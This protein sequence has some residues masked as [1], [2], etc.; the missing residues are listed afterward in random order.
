MSPEALRARL[1]AEVQAAG[2]LPP[3]W[4]ETFEAVPRHLF[5]PDT[6]WVEA[7]RGWAPLSRQSRPQ[8][9]WDLVYRDGYVVTQ[10]DD[11]RAA[12]P[13]AVGSYSTSS[14]SQPSLVMQMLRQLDPGPGDRVLEIGTGSGYNAALL[15][16]RVGAANVTTVEISESLAQQARI[17]LDEAGFGQTRVLVGDGTFGW[18]PAAPYDRVIS[19]AGVQRVPYDWVAQTRA[20]G[21]IVTPWGTGYHNDAL[22]KLTVGAD[23]TASGGFAGSA[24]F[25][26]MRDQRVILGA[27]S[28]YVNEADRP[29]QRQTRLDPQEMFGRGDVD[30]AISTRVR[31]CSWHRF[32]ATGGPG[33]FTV[34]LVHLGPGERSWASI[35]REPDGRHVVEQY[36]PR[37]LWDEVEAAYAWWVDIGR[38]ARERFGL[39]V[40][41]DRQTVWL[42]T[43]AAPVST[44]SWDTGSP[45]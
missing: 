45:A 21:V 6:V 43:S 38:P 3:R 20:G 41:P 1:T 15:A 19:T 37:R 28:D 29:D 16:G 39:T 9:W 12:E 5:I 7:D 2:A 42:D 33:E 27:L 26:W 36:G 25:M 18:R 30:F 35:D 44:Q 40:T 17:T 24:P 32:D 14:A 31:D 4:R 34:W 22:V 13:G 11:G 23:G 8:E 10:V